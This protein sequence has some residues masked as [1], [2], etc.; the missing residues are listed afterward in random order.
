MNSLCPLAVE[1]VASRLPSVVS[2]PLTPLHA[3]C[4]TPLAVPVKAPSPRPRPVCDVHQVSY[5][6]FS[7]DQWMLLSG[8]RLIIMARNKANGMA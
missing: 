4:E 6:M 1:R 7:S 3:L 2:S 8:G 5:S